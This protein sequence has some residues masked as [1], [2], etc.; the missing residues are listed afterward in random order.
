MIDQIIAHLR[1]LFHWN[2]PIG[3]WVLTIGFFILAAIII[4]IAIWL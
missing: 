2:N 1:K 4:A 3:D